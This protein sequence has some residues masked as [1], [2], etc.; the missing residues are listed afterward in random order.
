MAV[1]GKIAQHLGGNRYTV[2]TPQG[3]IDVNIDDPYRH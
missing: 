3:L 1:S 2:E